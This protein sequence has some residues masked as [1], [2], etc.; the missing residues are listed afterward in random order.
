YEVSH[1]INGRWNKGRLEI[2]P[3]LT[4]TNPFIHATIS[5]PS[6]PVEIEVKKTETHIEIKSR[7]EKEIQIIV[8]LQNSKRVKIK[9]NEIKMVA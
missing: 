9:T 7:S 2:E 8:K 1:T 6:G 5:T 3:I 4:D